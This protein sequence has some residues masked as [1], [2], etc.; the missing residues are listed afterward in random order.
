M[1][2]ASNNSLFLEQAIV[3][4]VAEHHRDAGRRRV[5]EGDPVLTPN[6]WNGEIRDKLVLD[7]L[8]AK[9][10]DAYRWSASQLEKYAQ[11]P[12]AFFVER[13]LELDEPSEFEYQPSPKHLGLI[14]HD[15]LAV[16][17]K[18][19]KG[20]LPECLEGVSLEIFERLADEVFSQQ[21]ESAPWIP[22]LWGINKRKIRDGVR[23]YI[24]AELTSLAKNH[25]EPHLME[26]P[27]GY[28][29]PLTIQ[30]TNMAGRP[31]KLRI[32]GSIDRVD[33]YLEAGEV[34]HHVLDYKWK[35][36]PS[37]NG[38]ED[39][40]V[41]QGPIY[42]CAIRIDGLEPGKCRYRRI[43]LTEPKKISNAAQTRADSARFN[44]AMTIAFSIP[45]RV[46]GGLFEA[47]L[48][49]TMRTW[50]WHFPGR[51]LCRSQAVLPGGTRFDD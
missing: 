1:P 16:F 14:A 26:H 7:E 34:V 38:Y 24:E 41:L 40:S 13:V 44:Q 18:T 8:E 12:F 39:G 36:T 4:A 43:D 20:N 28:D 17:Y 22:A 5:T 47:S 42:L 10:G 19:T 6:P 21:E 49:A 31:V 25:E 11:C 3:A 15:L 27:F 50:P 23:A 35:N 51:E 2:V 37:R 33:R 46:R 45:E 29:E 9:F 48:A 30:G 32:C